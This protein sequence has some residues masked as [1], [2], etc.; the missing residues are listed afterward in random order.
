MEDLKRMVEEVRQSL[1]EMLSERDRAELDAISA[2][3]SI[4]SACLSDGYTEI[5][6]TFKPYGVEVVLGN[7]VYSFWLD[8]RENIDYNYVRDAVASR[9]QDIIRRCLAKLAATLNADV[10]RRILELERRIGDIEARLS[11]DCDP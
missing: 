9:A 11:D 1:D 6:V 3:L 4:V 10:V 5:P 7:G 8:R 2:T